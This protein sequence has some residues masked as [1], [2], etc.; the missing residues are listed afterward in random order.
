MR[1]AISA[2]VARILREERNPSLETPLRMGEVLEV[3]LG[4]IIRCARLAAAKRM[5]REEQ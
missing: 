1:A 3:P 5:S 2:E 4:Q